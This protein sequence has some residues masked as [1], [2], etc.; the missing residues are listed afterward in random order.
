M[1]VMTDNR[2]GIELPPVR[3]E[4][5]AAF[6]FAREARERARRGETFDGKS[7]EEPDEDSAGD[8]VENFAADFVETIELSLSFVGVDEM[9]HLNA[10]YRNRPEPTDVLSFELDDPW[11]PCSG[12][13]MPRVLMGDI[14]ICPDVAREHAKR[15]GI[16]L[17]EQL[18]ILVIHGIL[19]LL[20]YDH[21][22][23]EEARAMEAREDEHLCQWKQ[24]LA[25][26]ALK[27]DG[28]HGDG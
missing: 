24:H 20:G 15:D 14:V 19:H 5:L 2:S 3:V 13:D 17:D 12:P 25:T 7:A 8:F 9:A 4:E 6:V 23:A 21:E 11:A 27:G 18:R 16:G 22:N 26:A 10:T 28:G 1:E